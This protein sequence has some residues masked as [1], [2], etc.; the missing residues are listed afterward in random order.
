MNLSGKIALV[1]GAA[2]RV[3]KAVALALAESGARVAIHYHRSAADVEPLVA[4]LTELGASACAFQA[5]LADSA[6]IATL[7]RAVHE[8]FGPLDILVNNA[9]VFH[10]TP[11]DDLD[12][13]GWDTVMNVNLRAPFLCSLLF[14]RQMKKAG[15]GRIINIADASSVRPS[16]D[17]IPYC[18]SKSALMALTK[19]MA[20][21]LAP[22]VQVTC[23][24]PGVVL[25]PDDLEEETLQRMRRSI[26]LRRFGTPQD[27]S[28]TVL[29]L[30]ACGDFITGSTIFVDGGWIAG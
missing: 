13:A 26:P 29:F 28:R 12:V 15:R 8:R 25:P 2:R 1:T 4:R 10:R 7:A 3:G 14:G 21:A 16:P 22:E 30:A 23:V 27:V 11:L 6:Q 20:K 24:A 19:A 17:Y 9:S 18:V 5:D